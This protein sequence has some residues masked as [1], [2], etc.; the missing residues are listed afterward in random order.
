MAKIK[1]LIFKV[2]DLQKDH[3]SSSALNL[4]K[5]DIHPG[6]IYGIV[7]NV[8]SGKSTLLNILAGCEKESSGTVL[9]DDSP[10]E[11]NWLGKI[12]PPDD[13]FYTKELSLKTPNSTVSSYIATKFGKKKNVIQNRY[14]EDGSFK[15]LWNR[16]MKDISSGE[17]NWL[18]MILACEEDPRVLLIDDYGV[19]FNN[20]MER[21]FRAKI[22]SMNRTLGTTIILSAPSDI[23]IKHFASVLIYL[24]H[25]HIWKIRSGIARNSNSNQ[26]N[27]KKN[28]N[29]NNNRSRNR[30]RS[31]RRQ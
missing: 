9:Y 30:K 29:R 5:L 18:G 27:D 28:R 26:R 8:G 7:G 12:R 31:Q 10:Y 15:N 11:T 4:K 2:N 21:D 3:R 16:N 25:G 13:V 23:N 1:R 22:T 20:K 17:L 14:F 19:Y 6:T 24:D